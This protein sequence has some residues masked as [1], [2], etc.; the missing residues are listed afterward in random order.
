MWS[1]SRTSVDGRIHTGAARPKSQN[2]E[3]QQSSHP[4]WAPP[5]P[6]HTQAGNTLPPP[7]HKMDVQ[8]PMDSCSI[9]FRSFS[10]WRE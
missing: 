3:C 10:I 6:A 1:A 2:P 5:P 8:S 7:D 4:L 9:D